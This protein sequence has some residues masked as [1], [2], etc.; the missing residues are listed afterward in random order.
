LKISK[1]EIIKKPIF[2]IHFEAGVY[3]LGDCGALSR[4]NM[5]AD[6]F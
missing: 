1:H 3:P 6:S 4:F 5:A 2:T